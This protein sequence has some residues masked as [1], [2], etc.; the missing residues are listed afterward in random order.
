[1]AGET[2]GDWL[3]S[4]VR[5]PA[6]QRRANTSAATP[7][8]YGG[9]P[10]KPA[11]KLPEMPNGTAPNGSTPPAGTAGAPPTA[12]E[13]EEPDPTKRLMKLI[14]KLFEEMNKPL[15]LNDPAVKQVL[16]QMRADTMQDAGNRGVY[17]GYSNAMG[18]QAYGRGA[19]Q[20][21][22][23]KKGM[24]MNALGMLTG[25][26]QNQRDFDY[27]KGMDLWSI[28]QANNPAAKW[29]G[30]LGGLTGALAGGAGGDVFGGAQAG[31][32]IGT[33][34]AQMFN[35]TPPPSFKGYG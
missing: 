32:Q 21:A 2:L 23:Q 19:N 28:E 25:A 1:M 8:A 24:A 9:T 22:L 6:E 12:D 7:Y 27:R 18:E 4:I 10:M 16:D 11:S 13:A 5:L 34:A 20:L 31:Y 15:D 35:P 17:G 30:L 14:E 3:N 33:G 26:T 29:G